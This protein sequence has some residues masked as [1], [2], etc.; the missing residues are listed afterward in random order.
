MTDHNNEETTMNLSEL[1]KN[2]VAFDADY[3]QLN[4]G[5]E[6][7]RHILLHLMDSTGKIAAYCEK[8]EH[9]KNMDH[10]DQ[11][12]LNEI[13]PDFLIHSLQLANFFNQDL[14]EKYFARLEM[15][16]V[17]MSKILKKLAA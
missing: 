9:T 13:I 17:K 7:I 16:K 3:F 11:Q 15:N 5:F 12:L 10:H 1:Q 4:H 8:T 6:K 14:L 2:Q